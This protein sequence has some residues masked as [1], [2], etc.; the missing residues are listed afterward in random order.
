MDQNIVVDYLGHPCR[1]TQA[2]DRF[3][4]SLSRA[5]R[6]EFRAIK[7]NV[8]ESLLNLSDRLNSAL[9]GSTAIRNLVN[10]QDDSEEAGALIEMLVAYQLTT[11][12]IFEEFAGLILAGFDAEKSGGEA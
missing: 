1:F 2:K 7:R 3:S 8:G 4:D 9:Y 12:N 6:K 10:T 11:S 5:Q